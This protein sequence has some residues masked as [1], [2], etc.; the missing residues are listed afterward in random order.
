MIVKGELLQNLH[1]NFKEGVLK[2]KLLFVLVL[3]SLCSF[4]ISAKTLFE[5]YYK[6]DI[7]GKHIGYVI[8]KYEFLKSKQQYKSVYYVHFKQGTAETTEAVKALAQKDFK[9]ISFQYTYRD[10]SPSGSTKY[11]VIDANFKGLNMTGIM[12]EGTLNSKKKSPPKQLTL[13]I[14]K[15]SILSTFLIHKILATGLKNK[16]NYAYN[17][18]AEENGNLYSGYA[19]I[20]GTEVISGRTLYKVEN[21][22]KNAAFVNHMDSFGHVFRFLS[23]SINLRGTLVKSPAEATKG[24][25]MDAKALKELFGAV[26]TGKDNNLVKKSN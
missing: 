1:F 4:N 23:P 15:D 8:Q 6:L 13:K 24:L 11:K 12:N 16:T 18:V 2:V 3:A 21:N 5:G 19:K 9:P 17:A 22:F 26:P 10:K 7:A 25:Q 14:R 20:N